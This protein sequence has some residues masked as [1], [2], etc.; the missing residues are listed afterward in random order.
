MASLV[1]NELF[2]PVSGPTVAMLGMTVIILI[3]GE[4][5]PKTLSVKKSYKLSLAFA[6]PLNICKTVMKPVVFVV[7]QFVKKISFL[8]T[9]KNKEHTTDE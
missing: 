1:A 6:F 7:S 4:I 5:L 3:F 8:W 2:G 9:S